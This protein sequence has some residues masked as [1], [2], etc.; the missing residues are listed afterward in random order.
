MK[1]Y[2]NPASPFVRKCRVVALELHIAL[3]LAET[4]ARDDESLRRIN[5]LKKIPALVL[6][7]GAVL[8]DSRVIC[9][10]LDAVGEGAFFPEGIARWTALRR[11]ALA[12]GV[13][14]AAVAN[15]YEVIQPPGK[16]NA[17]FM[18]R[19]MATIRAGLEALERE[20][21]SAEPAIGEIAIGCMLGYLDFR[22]GDL[23]WRASHPRLAAWFGAFAQR[24][25]MAATAPPKPA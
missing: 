24:P 10:Y 1:L 11:Q 8:Y 7:D 19:Y 13:M 12:D 23:G 3:D 25:A 14:D 20:T 18:V 6:D 21:L 9:E 17:D 22:Y 15:R 5:P 16:Q 4:T 2:F